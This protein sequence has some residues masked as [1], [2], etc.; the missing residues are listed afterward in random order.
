MSL[1]KTFALIRAVQAAGFKLVDSKSI[2][3]HDGSCWEATLAQGKTKL[4]KVHN[5]GY[6]GPD[7]TYF[8]E[9]QTLSMTS[10][11]AA[12]NQLFA[13]AEVERVVRDHQI[14][15]KGYDLKYQHITQEQF[16]AYKAEIEATPV[17]TSEEAIEAVVNELADG[18][19][20]LKRIKRQLKTKILFT[21]VDQSESGT[22]VD[23]WYAVTAPDTPANRETLRKRHK[24]DCFLADLVDGL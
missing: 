4:V 24:I 23:S 9:N 6:G 17:T 8:L 15:L 19:D 21:Q 12:L 1:K 18:Y 13:I 5:G 3:T 16:D 11:K 20:S 7:E 14:T 22:A 10:I 2:G